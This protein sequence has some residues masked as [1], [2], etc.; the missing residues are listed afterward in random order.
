MIGEYYQ[1]KRKLQGQFQEGNT[2]SSLALFGESGWRVFIVCGN[3]KLDV[4][5][6]DVPP[7]NLHRHQP[8]TK[9]HLESYLTCCE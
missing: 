3:F 8:S 9:I 1:G 5:S 2:S 7:M 4:H 6:S